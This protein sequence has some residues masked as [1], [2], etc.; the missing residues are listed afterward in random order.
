MF[1]KQNLSFKNSKVLN[2]LVQ[3]YIENKETIS[4][5]FDTPF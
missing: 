1:V 4:S 2:P 5:L 3:D